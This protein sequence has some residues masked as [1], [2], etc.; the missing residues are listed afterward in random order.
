MN[1]TIMESYELEEIVVA[2][3]VQGALL[4]NE[5]KDESDYKLAV[6]SVE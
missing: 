1:T 2:E 3:D 4:N 5:Q 6:R